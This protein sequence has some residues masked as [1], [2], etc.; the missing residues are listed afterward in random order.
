MTPVETVAICPSGLPPKLQRGTRVETV[1][2]S[3]LLCPAT[4]VA[5]DQLGQRGTISLSQIILTV[6]K[7]N[8][9]EA[10][11]RQLLVHALFSSLIEA[12]HGHII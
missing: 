1:A 9:I 5:E 11:K 4:T 12:A 10:G 2:A 8:Q 3:H 7:P 6:G